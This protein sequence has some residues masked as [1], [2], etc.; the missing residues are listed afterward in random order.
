[1]VIKFTGYSASSSSRYQ[2]LYS[3]QQELLEKVTWYAIPYHLWGNRKENDM[4]IWLPLAL[5]NH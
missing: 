1:M 5:L 4:R 2:T 3:N